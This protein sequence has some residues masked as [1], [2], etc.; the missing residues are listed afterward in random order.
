MFLVMWLFGCL[1]G[2]PFDHP[3]WIA[4]MFIWIPLA[5]IALSFLKVK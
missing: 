5:L 1:K 3:I 4:G 2:S